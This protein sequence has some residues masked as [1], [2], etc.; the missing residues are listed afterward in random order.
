MDFTRLLLPIAFVGAALIYTVWIRKRASQA[1]AGA[2]PAFVEFFRR[3]G[4]AFPDM[5]NL[6]PEAQAQRAL[7]QSS[8][9]TGGALQTHYVRNFHGLTIHN[10][11]RQGSE[12]RDGRNVYVVSNRWEAPLSRPPRLGI[13]IA[14]KRL[15]AFGA[16]LAREVLTNTRRHWS[17]A[18]PHPVTTGI[19][20]LDGRFAIFA[21][22]PAAA[23]ALFHQNPSLASLLGGWAELDVAVTGD[24]AYFADPEQKNMMAAMGGTIGSMAVGFDYGKRLEMAIPVH[25]RVAELLATLVRATA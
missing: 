11:S 2:G 15:G 21:T 25:D 23:A 4:Y 19:A 18:H 10:I 13:H 12:V 1:L 8:Q 7:S 9:P 24:R 20:E 16:N 14:D 3:T 17:P 6:P 22:D 5:A